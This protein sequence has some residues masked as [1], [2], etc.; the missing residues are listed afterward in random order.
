MKVLMS[1]NPTDHTKLLLHLTHASN[2]EIPAKGG[3]KKYTEIP[4]KSNFLQN[5]G[6]L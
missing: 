5:K 6:A 3:K 1:V 4:C 2:K